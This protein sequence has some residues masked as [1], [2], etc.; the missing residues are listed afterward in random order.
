MSAEDLEIMRRGYESFIATGELV[1]EFV[2]PEFV[3]DMS[4]FRGW[5]ER[6][7]YEG[8][9]GAREFLAA[10]VEAWDDWT[11][12]IEELHEAGD[13]IVAIAHQRGR[14]KATGLPVDMRFG[15]VWTIRDGKQVRMEMYATPEEAVA[16]AGLGGGDR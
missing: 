15:Q 2:D 6:Q 5:P 12:E 4:T 9:E 14:A 3:W 1:E 8:V 7:A 11:L 16:A 10:W 13:R